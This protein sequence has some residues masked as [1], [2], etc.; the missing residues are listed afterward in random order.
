[1]VSSQVTLTPSVSSA[2]SWVTVWHRQNLNLKNK[3][4]KCNQYLGIRSSGMWC[5]V[6]GRMVP[7]GSKDHIAVTFNGYPSRWRHQNPSKVT[8]HSPNNTSLHPTT[9]AIRPANLTDSTTLLTR[10][11]YSFP[12][13]G[14]TQRIECN[15][16]LDHFSRWLQNPKLE[17]VCKIP[18]LSIKIQK[19]T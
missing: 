13:R 8:N 2:A 17:P 12:G 5:R 10:A 18:T 15:P 11:Q 6:I 16:Q 14:Y 3:T 7:D 1:M 4:S 19:K 9:W